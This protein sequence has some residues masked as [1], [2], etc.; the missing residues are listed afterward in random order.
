MI[1]RIHHAGVGV[2]DEKMLKE[3]LHFYCDLLGLQVDGEVEYP[4]GELVDKAV[5]VE[6]ANLKVIHLTPPGAENWWDG[7]VELCYYS[8]PEPKEWR[9]GT[10]QCDG[11]L[12]HLALVVEDLQ[13]MYERLVKEGVTF[14]TE[15]LNLGTH[16]IVYMRDPDG[17]TVEL[18]EYLRE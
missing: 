5:D 2:R 18:M 10:R 3:M 1:K 9:G 14:N 17:N 12:I 6:N 7:G 11:G 16:V 13:G 15:P 4:E 8:S